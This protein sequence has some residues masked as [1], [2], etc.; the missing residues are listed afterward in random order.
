MIKKKTRKSSKIGATGRKIMTEAKKIRK[1]SPGKKW[2]TCVSQA[3][4]KIKK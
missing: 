2:T 3:A 4:K 1:A